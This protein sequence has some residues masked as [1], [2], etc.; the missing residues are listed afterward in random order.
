MWVTSHDYYSDA[1]SKAQVADAAVLQR[2]DRTAAC[3]VASIA[4]E[5]FVL[6]LRAILFHQKSKEKSEAFEKDYAETYEL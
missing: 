1:I 4:N 3:M 5:T 2:F 6:I